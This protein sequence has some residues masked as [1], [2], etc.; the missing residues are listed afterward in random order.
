MYLV[1]SITLGIVSRIVLRTKK[2]KKKQ[3]VEID[4]NLVVANVGFKTAMSIDSIL[5]KSFTTRSRYVV[6]SFQLSFY[7]IYL[8]FKL[9]CVNA[10]RTC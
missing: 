7:L 6:I 8:F 5:I 10:Y 3:V 2:K 1:A 9:V 4:L